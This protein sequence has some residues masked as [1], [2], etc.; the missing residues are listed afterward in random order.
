M[1]KQLIQNK[2]IADAVVSKL[3]NKLFFSNMA[4]TVLE[5][6][7]LMGAG[8]GKTK[9][10]TQFDIEQ[11]TLQVLNRGDEIIS[12][13]LGQSSFD[14]TI[15]QLAYGKLFYDQDVKYNI[16][17]GSLDAV[18]ELDILETF[19]HG[20]DD[21]A[22]Q[23][24]VNKTIADGQVVDASGGLTV[25]MII[26]EGANVF[27]EKLFDG[28]TSALVVHPT[29]ITQL[30]NDPNFEK[31][32]TYEN[33]TFGNQEIGRIFGTIPVVQLNKVLPADTEGKF[34]NILVPKEAV[35]SV[36]GK[37]LNVERERIHKK[38]AWDITADLFYGVHAKTSGIIFEA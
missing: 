9:T 2:V 3:P 34:K 31:A 11:G 23:A 19:S 16:S 35:I 12:T 36:Y 27:G 17:G 25:D 14:V 1:N 13:E 15:E 37:N 20:L 24:L 21:M 8:V 28:A 7:D 29:K 10:Y 6:R 18:A 30:L 38:R 5:D 26:S 4:G 22:L 32:T 33:K